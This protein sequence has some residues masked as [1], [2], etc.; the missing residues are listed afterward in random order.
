MAVS[1]WLSFWF[2]FVYNGCNY[3]ASLRDDVGNCAFWWERYYPF[4]PVLIIPYWSIDLLFVVAPFFIPS[5][6]L[7]RQ[8]VKR[9]TMGIAIAGFFFLNFPLTLIYQRPLVTG[10][11]GKLFGSLENFNNFYNCAPSL[12]ITLR[13]NLWSIYV[14]PTRGWR[15]AL[16]GGWFGLIGLSTLLCWQHYIIDVVSG[17][18]LGLFCLF[19]FPSVPFHPPHR[20]PGRGINARPDLGHFYAMGSLLLVLLLVLGWPTAFPLM[21]PALSL[22]LVAAAYYRA[23]PTFLRKFQ[24]KQLLGSR[25]LLNPYRWVL[26]ATARHFNQGHPP[27]GE[28]EPGMYFGR[29]L[30]AAEASRLPVEAVLDLTAEYDEVAPFLQRTY[31]NLPVL[32]LTAPSPEQLRQAVD[33]LQLHP[34]C[35][36]H[37]SLGLG[38]TVAVGVAYLM[39]HRGLDLEAALA[40][41]A[42]VRPRMRLAPATLRVL[43]ELEAG[44]TARGGA[45]SPQ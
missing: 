10:F 11:L 39:L 40:R 45:G 31:L 4:V 7:L 44:A 42:E 32:D 18:L 12:H 8:H 33:F 15:R 1:A 19:I 3:L 23:G 36:V 6:F 35:Y 14:T 29:R 26:A 2:V 37:C 30:S 25:W 20:D 22:A 17:Q 9:I 24:G 21:W 27:Y 28:L 13:T 34:S 41:M 5:S 38:R 43:A 16:I